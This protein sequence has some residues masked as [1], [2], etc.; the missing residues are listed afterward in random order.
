MND[1]SNGLKHNFNNY[2]LIFYVA[3]QMH[4]IS[5]AH[6]RISFTMDSF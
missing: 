3:K 2:Q 6:D 5:T 1:S 4:I